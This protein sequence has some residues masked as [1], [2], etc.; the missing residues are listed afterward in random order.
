MNRTLRSQA[1]F[2]LVELLVAIM[3]L[4]V[5]LLGLAELQISAMKQNAKSEQIMAAISLG[6]MIVEDV[7][8]RGTDDPLFRN[9][10]T[11]ANWSLLTPMPATA[12]VYEITVPGAGAFRITYDTVTEYQGVDNLCLFRVHI[13]SPN[14]LIGLGSLTSPVTMTTIKRFVPAT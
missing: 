8:N 9:D 1:G 14:R 12:P 3:I 7:A 2:S 5:A 6:Q 11:G 4:A 10:R 13:R